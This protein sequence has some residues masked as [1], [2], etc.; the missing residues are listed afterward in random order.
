VALGTQLVDELEECRRRGRARGGARSARRVARGEQHHRASGLA[1]KR[2]DH[3]SQVDLVA[4][5]LPGEPLLAHR[6]AVHLREA[7]LDQVRDRGVA[8]AAGR[9][10]GRGLD[11]LACDPGGGELVELGR[12]HDPRQRI[13]RRG[14]REEQHDDGG[15]GRCKPCTVDPEI[16]HERVCG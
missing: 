8:V 10:F 5:E 14:E 11:D 12:R 7:L 9:G 1:G 6:A 2:E 3:V 15:Q 16:D 13:G 4:G